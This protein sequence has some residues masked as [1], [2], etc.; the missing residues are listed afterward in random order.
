MEV[1]CFKEPLFSLFSLSI[2]NNKST[3]IFLWTSFKK[4]EARFYSGIT[5]IETDL[6][7][8]RFLFVCLFLGFFLV[9]FPLLSLNHSFQLQKLPELCWERSLQRF[10]M[11][12]LAGTLSKLSAQPLM[13]WSIPT[14]SW[15]LIDP[16]ENYR[17]H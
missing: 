7:D 15:G 17:F 4:V 3:N 5:E 10:F 9:F 1:L 13:I 16:M 2:W 8:P 12:F 14:I 6:L 11:K